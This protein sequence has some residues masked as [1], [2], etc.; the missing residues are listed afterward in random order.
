M[1]RETSKPQG[2]GPQAGITRRQLLGMG[3]AALGLSAATLAVGSRIIA[4]PAA[5]ASVATA[6]R[7]GM[8]ID[9]DRCFGCRSCMEACKVENNTPK[10]IFWMHV[11][12]FQEGR[13][14]D[15]R[16]GY[17]PRPCMHCDNP[18]CVKACPH[19]A[20]YKR[21]D[22][23][24]AT[25]Y[26]TCTG[27]R[28][29]HAACPYG[30][31]YFNRVEPAQNY[32]RDWASVTELNTVTGGAVPPY[33]NPDLDAK[34]GEKLI[35]GGGHFKDVI[36]KCTF[37]VH[38]LA[39]GLKP[40]CA[41]NCPVEAIHFGDLNDPDSDVS[42]AIASKRSFRL[43]EEYGTSPKVYYIGKAPLATDSRQMDRV[44]GA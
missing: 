15:V 3:G 19:G 7:Y 16:V 21:D 26:E 39:K 27:C 5:Q 2:A 33:K 12:R 20:R 22:G 13:Y 9:L 25:D 41:A 35:A 18:P 30:A 37:C 42:R 24:V 43:R 23:L 29:C 28:Y 4:S 11:F 44:G 34:Y 31:N 36:E 1:T 10:G 38:R 17:L 40:A 32:Y 8:A 6:V 14:P